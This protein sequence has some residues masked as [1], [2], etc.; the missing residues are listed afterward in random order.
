LFFKFKLHIHS[1]INILC[2]ELTNISYN[3]IL[4][5]EE[6]III[7][8]K[9]LLKIL[10]D[11]VIEEIDKNIYYL[12]DKKIQSNHI[13]YHTVI[14]HT[15]NENNIFDFDQFFIIKTSYCCIYIMFEMIQ[16]WKFTLWISVIIK[17]KD[18]DNKIIIIKFDC[19]I[20]KDRNVTAK[21]LSSE[22]LSLSIWYI[23][24]MQ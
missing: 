1:H 2:S 7:N 21:L 24:K 19:N 8:S 5:T 16:K 14:M 23:A 15:D 22:H 18:A 10:N 13:K 12:N 6:L 3:H 11:N 17:K 20:I 9:I 4:C